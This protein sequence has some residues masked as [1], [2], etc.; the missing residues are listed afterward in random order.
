[1]LENQPPV[2]SLWSSREIWMIPSIGSEESSARL[3][4]R[5]GGLLLLL[6]LLPWQ[7]AVVVVGSWRV[8]LLEGHF[9]TRKGEEVGFSSA[10]GFGGSSWRSIR[11]LWR[12]HRAR[13]NVG[14]GRI[15]P[16][17]SDKGVDE[18]LSFRI[19]DNT[20]KSYFFSSSSLKKLKQSTI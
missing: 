7:R 17:I 15:Q 1:M 6:L 12:R 11:R 20:A 5:A 4:R 16:K 10:V 9:G 13:E 14:S 19:P 3:L 8:E 18:G 2:V